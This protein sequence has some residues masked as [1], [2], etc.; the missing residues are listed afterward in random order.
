MSNQTPDRK[1]AAPPLRILAALVGAAFG[2]YCGLMI[3]IP[4]A[5][6]MGALLLG[7]RFA[8]VPLKCFGA[9]LAVLF[10]HSMWMLIGA[11]W[12][13]AGFGPLLFDLAII[14]AGSL[15]L[16][17]RPGIGSVILLGIYEFI[18]LIVNIKDIFSYEFATIGHRALSAHIALRLVALFALL[19]GYRQFLKTQADKVVVAKSSQI[20][21]SVPVDS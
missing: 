6:A 3:L 15:W 12:L 19:A 17:L 14:I 7:K 20:E 5:I 16:M 18:G 10:G 4:L 21:Q 1:P 9:A 8:S 13:Q 11:L 2:I